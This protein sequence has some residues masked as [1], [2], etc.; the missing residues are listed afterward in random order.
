VKLKTVGTVALVIGV[1]LGGALA[2]RMLPAPVASP[3]AP[4]ISPSTA[5]EQKAGGSMQADK[6]VAPDATAKPTEKEIPV[7]V[8]VD[9]GTRQPTDR[10]FTIELASFR[11]LD[12]AR[13]YFAEMKNRKLA[14]RL[15]ESMDVGGALWYHV[16]V[17]EFGEFT[18]ANARLPEVARTTGL[19]GVIAE[20]MPVSS[21]G[22]MGAEAKGR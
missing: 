20:E 11:S 2:G 8:R 13:D 15:V 18:Q 9:D 6:A 14:V 21:S 16:R 22:K 19:S 1:G 5:G 7:P 12:R 3:V 17:G 10:I 4:A